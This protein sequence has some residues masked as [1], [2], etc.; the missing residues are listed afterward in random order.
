MKIPVVFAFDD[1]YALP[2]SI[3]ILNNVKVC[4]AWGGGIPPF[5]CNPR[6]NGT[7]S[8]WSVNIDPSVGND[9]QFVQLLKRY[10]AVKARLV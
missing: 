10:P 6:A 7:S 8:L 3:A 2:A 1:N 4:D 9:R 5:Q